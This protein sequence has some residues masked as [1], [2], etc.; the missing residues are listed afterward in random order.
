MYFIQSKKKED[1]KPLICVLSAPV[2]LIFVLSRASTVFGCMCLLSSLL[3]LYSTVQYS[4]VNKIIKCD[5]VDPAA[6]IHQ[7]KKQDRRK[8]NKTS[9][10]SNNRDTTETNNNTQQRKQVSSQINLNRERKRKALSN[11]DPPIAIDSLTNNTL[12]THTQHTTPQN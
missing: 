11:T 7:A 12:E 5:R 3:V 8:H 9:H 1:S 2:L 4:T 6:T 10:A